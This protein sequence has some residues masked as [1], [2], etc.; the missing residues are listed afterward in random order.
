MQKGSFHLLVI[1]LVLLLLGVVGCDRQ[2]APTVVQAP[3]PVVCPKGLPF[4]VCNNST[5]LHGQIM[6]H[7]KT[8]KSY[9]VSV[10]THGMENPDTQ[11]I[12]PGNGWTFTGVLQGDR[13]ITAKPITGGE[14]IESHIMVQGGMQHVAEINYYGIKQVDGHMSHK[15]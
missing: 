5:A 12:M 6:I 9:N 14:T 13:M 4:S 1:V 8:N 11:H 10:Y 7:N 15:N 2:Q 3:Q